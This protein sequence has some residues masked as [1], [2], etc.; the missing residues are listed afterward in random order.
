MM[1]LQVGAVITS[2]LSLSFG[3]VSRRQFVEEDNKNENWNWRHMVIDMVWNVLSISPRVIAFAFF[4]S[5]ELSWFWGIAAF[6]IVIAFA[7]SF[8]YNWF[9]DDKDLLTIILRSI[10]EGVGLQFTMYTIFQIR[11]LFYLI[12]WLFT[13]IENTVLISLWY[14]WSSDLS[15]W[16]RDITISCVIPG[17]FLSLIVKTLHTSYWNDGWKNIS[18]WRYYSYRD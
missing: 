8:W 6:Q 10:Y 14:V 18:W 13:F 12:Y 2:L 16:Y 9:Y 17:Y 3:F 7:I 15:L 11:F 5:F 1:I 4:A